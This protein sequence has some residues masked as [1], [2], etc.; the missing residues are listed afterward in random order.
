MLKRLEL[1]G[2]KSFADKT[3]LDFDTGITGIVGPNGSG[4]SNVVDAIRWILGEQSAK[5]LRGKEMADVIFNGSGGRR[6]LGM[7]EVSLVLDNHT[8]FLPI[9][10]DE[11][12]LTRRVY[13]SGEGEYLINRK[14]ARLRDIRDLFLGT[15]AGVGAYSII[16]QGKVEQ[17]LQTSTKDRRH[18]FDE[19]AGISRFKARKIESLRR[20]DRVEQNLLRVQDIREEV[21]KQLRALR[22]QAGKARKAKEY[23]DRLREQRLTLGRDE[24][25]ALTTRLS[26]VETRFEAMRLTVEESGRELAATQERHDRIDATLTSR[27]ESIRKLAE[28]TGELRQRISVVETEIAGN[29]ARARELRDEIFEGLKSTNGAR[30]RG[31]NLRQ[32]QEE[33]ES[34]I[35]AERE[36]QERE[37]GKLAARQDARAEGVERL[38][39]LQAAL[40]ESEREADENLKRLAR[41]ENDQAGLDSQLAFLW[42]Q[43]TRLDD[44]RRRLVRDGAAQCREIL[45]LTGAERSVRLQALRF[46]NDACDLRSER[47]ELLEQREKVL[48]RCSEVRDRRTALASRIDVLENL[49]RRH[50]GLEGGVRQALERRSSGDSVWRPVLGVLAERLEVS[51]ELADLVELALGPIAQALIVRSSQDLS[52]EL[53]AAARALPGRVH[54]VALEDM[55]SERVIVYSDDPHNPSLA[56]QVTCDEELQ[57]LIYRL[58]GTTFVLDDFPEAL[59]AA[60]ST[61]DLTYLT[62][63]GELLDADGTLSAGP[64]HATSGILSRVAELRELSLQV[65]PTDRLMADSERALAALDER[66][67][68]LRDRSNRYDEKEAVFAE[69]RR[70]FDL[71]RRRLEQRRET[72]ESEQSGIE[73]EAARTLS[74]IAE[75]DRQCVEIAREL[76]TTHR[77]MQQRSARSRELAANVAEAERHNATIETESAAARTELA[78]F[79]ERLVALEAQRDRLS[80]DLDHQRLESEAFS[81]RLGAAKSRSAETVRRLLAARAI[82]AESYRQMESIGA[83]ESF[84]PDQIAPMRAERAQLAGDLK[85]LRAAGDEARQRL[86]ADELE[87]TELRLNRDG[88]V[89][90]I[91]EDYDIDLIETAATDG[92]SDPDP[93]LDHD[94]IRAEITD[95][96]DKLARLGSVNLQAVEEL[97]EL[98]LRS[99][100]LEFQI[101]DLNSAKKRLEDVI[102]KINEESRRLFVDTF[103][104]VRVHFQE[105]FRRLFGGGKAD[106]L[107]EDET[108]VLETGIEVIARPPGKEPRSISLLSGG[109]KTLTATALILA[110]F[111]SKPSPFCILDEVDAALDEANI[112]RFIGVLKEFLSMSQFVLITH[113]KTTMACTD[114]LHGIT[115]RES[116]ISTRISVRLEDVSE[117]GDLLEGAAD[118]AELATG[119]EADAPAE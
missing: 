64:A 22:N 33:L 93:E 19:A 56:S 39:S 85:R 34:R 53:I 104:T 45:E 113:S 1:I 94:A 42:Q 35:D 119:E 65:E 38:R 90:R 63:T 87:A 91:K 47:A 7:A 41:L 11:V 112:G 54:F 15:G 14:L 84:D 116:G 32:R 73:A 62:A 117:D 40:E 66:M 108:D 92:V 105:V 6:S 8:G 52:A 103:E 69:Q 30:R 2:F 4:K 109:E 79:E 31:A 5:S 44:K 3:R 78:V 61:S 60:Q 9:E 106:L 58:L 51:V 96:R 26:T 88:L 10:S 24:Y 25:H 36:L 100:T 111:R 98:E 95:L 75:V 67:V 99:R 46:R 110:L 80:A 74:E 17:L 101:N 114:V 81:N 82:L 49:Q 29:D 115:Q 72:L 97:E 20:L 107:L 86:H 89:E 83:E 68:H 71:R 43:S 37:R 59:L 102:E 12:V 77:N 23:A 118:A 55:Q 27:E 13:R 76:A 16:E 50:E 48:L 57:S 21:D 28:R 70:H 18:I